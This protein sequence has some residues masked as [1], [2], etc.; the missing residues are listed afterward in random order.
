MN[1]LLDRTFEAVSKNDTPIERDVFERHQQA[2][3]GWEWLEYR[4]VFVLQ[5]RF[6]CPNFEAAMAKAQKVAELAET[7]D[8]HPVLTIEWGRM[9]VNW[10]THLIGGVH[11][12]D[13]LLA[14]KTEN[15]LISE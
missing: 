8:H 2:L 3:P 4:N 15:I 1:T 12:N 10:W 9:Q 14:A 6:A 5:K 11:M 7:Y 13:L